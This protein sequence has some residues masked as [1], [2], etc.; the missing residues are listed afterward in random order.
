MT[1]SWAHGIGLFAG[2]VM[3][4]GGAH[5][6]IQAIAAIANDKYLLVLPNYVYAF[7]ITAWGW[8]HLLLG[9]ILIAVGI[10][11]LL[12]QGWA[13]I[14]GIVVASISAVVNFFW[15]PYSPVWAV[16][17]I[18]IDLLVIWALASSH[19]SRARTA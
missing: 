15:L 8:I 16:V 13:H 11:L 7:D 17:V 9:V 12:G 14:A 2:V 19:S 4:I 6:A 3:I 10:C 18:A 5:Q 1:P